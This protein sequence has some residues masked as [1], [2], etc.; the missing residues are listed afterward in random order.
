MS[1]STLNE[2]HWITLLYFTLMK[3][4]FTCAIILALHVTC[5]LKAQAI[6]E[7][8]ITIRSGYDSFPVGF[9]RM[10]WEGIDESSPWFKTKS[11]ISGLP[12][13]WPAITVGTIWFDGMQ[14]AFQNFKQGLISEDFYNQVKQA[15]NIPFDKRRFSASPIKCFVNVIYGKN[16]SGNIRFMLDTDNDFDFSDE[17]EQVPQKLDWKAIDSL[18]AQFSIS[19]KYESIRNGMIVELIAPVLILER[20]GMLA[21]NIPLHAEAFLGKTK[22]M[23]RSQQ[24]NSIDFEHISIYSQNQ[25]KKSEV[26]EQNEFISVDNVSYKCLGVNIEKE[27][28][29]LQEMPLDTIIYSSQV[30]FNAYSFVAKEFTSSEELTLESFRGKYL[31]LDFWGSW[32]SPC[33]QELPALIKIYDSID[34]SKIDFLGIASD[35]HSSLRKMI[36]KEKIRWKQI[37]VKEDDQVIKNY[38]ITKYPTSF[39]I[40]PEGKILA[41]NIRADKLLDILNHFLDSEGR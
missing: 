16:Q 36:D 13:N 6:F 33:V 18:A 5:I 22:I 17:Q 3:A 32:C 25:S 14:F 2:M 30:G 9:G 26:V 23:I 15:W 4:R 35:N 29:L 20:D 40:S 38:G 19:V 21:R 12:L 39:L 34:K 24:F 11:N 10:N 41:K 31:F 28:L 27:M 1:S 7:L 37:M 8:P